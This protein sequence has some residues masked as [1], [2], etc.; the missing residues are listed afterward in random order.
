[1][2]LLPFLVVGPIVLEK[3][4]CFVLKKNSRSLTCKLF[5][6]SSARI[7]AFRCVRSSLYASLLA[8][9]EPISEQKVATT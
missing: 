3:R 8:D 5:G 2:D 4:R 1:M 9:I 7:K 6:S